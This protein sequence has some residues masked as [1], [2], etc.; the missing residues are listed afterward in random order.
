MSP[1]KVVLAVNEGFGGTLVEG[2]V[3]ALA[4]W[5]ISLIVL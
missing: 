3:A 1:A 2:G 5:V 4:V